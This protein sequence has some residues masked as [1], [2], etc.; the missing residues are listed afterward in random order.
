MNHKGH[1]RVNTNCALTDMN[2]EQSSRVE[3][4]RFKVLAE[5]TFAPMGLRMAYLSSLV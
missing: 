1:A 2:F 3:I 4:D 5:I